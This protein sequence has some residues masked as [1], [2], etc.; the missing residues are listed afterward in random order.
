ML[1]KENVNTQIRSMPDKFTLDELI[2]KLIVVE[3]IE[4]G[5]E[6]VKEGKTI[7]EEELDKRM[8]E[9]FK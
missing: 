7:T 5:I 8:Q 1:T 3:K 2:E 6:Q 9:W 4:I